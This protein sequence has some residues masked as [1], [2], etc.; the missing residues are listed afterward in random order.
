MRKCAE[1]YDKHELQNALNYCIERDL[2]SANDFRDTL[3]FFRTDEPK[4]SLGELLLPSKYQSVQALVRSLDS[5]SA[6]AKG[7][8]AV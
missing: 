4:N 8:D 3:V 7:G 6:A 2:F 5:Y 1:D